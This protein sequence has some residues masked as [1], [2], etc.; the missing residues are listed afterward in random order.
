MKP[1]QELIFSR[2]L[3]LPGFGGGIILTTQIG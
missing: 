2:T 1:V 3:V